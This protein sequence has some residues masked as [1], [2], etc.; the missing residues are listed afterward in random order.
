MLAIHHLGKSQSERIVWLCEELGVPYELKH[1]VR[2]PKTMLAPPD[3]NALHPVGTAPVV[4]EG[5]LTLA[6]SGAIVDYILARHGGGRL[7]VGADAP[8]FPDYL[9]WLHFTNGTLQPA[10]GRNMVVARAGVAPD[11]PFATAM[12]YRLRLAVGLVETRQRRAA[13][14]YAV[15]IEQGANNYSAYVPDSPGCVAVGDTLAEIESEI[16][17][18]ITF[19]IEGMQEDGL[20]IRAPLSTPTFTK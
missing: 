18:A 4:I 20:T 17:E 13:M 10:F 9:Y 15:V 7:A 5:A 2:D 3:Y 16:R 8:N 1:Y 19:H 6:E 14:R 12:L 11:S